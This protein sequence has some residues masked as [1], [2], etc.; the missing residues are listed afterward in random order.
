MEQENSHF[1]KEEKAIWRVNQ[2]SVS[3]K[4]FYTL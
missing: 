2:I 4:F 1:S 3:E